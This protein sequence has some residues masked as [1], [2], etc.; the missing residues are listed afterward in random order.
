VPGDTNRNI[1]V[2]ARYSGRTLKHILVPVW[3]VNY[4]YG[5]KTFQVLTNGYTGAIAGERPYSWI[6]IALA[7]AT[8]ALLVI[9][10]IY[11]GE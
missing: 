4:T 1:Q 6:K 7:V 9:T 5:S 2:N 3:L 10:I 11:S 8:V